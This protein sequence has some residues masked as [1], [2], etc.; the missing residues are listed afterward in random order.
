MLE[1]NF[2]SIYRAIDDLR[3]IAT[4]ESAQN[5]DT[6]RS[7]L[8]K[9]INKFFGN[10]FVCESIVYTENFDKPFFGVFVK[11]NV[12][13]NLVE[14][15]FRGYAPL[16]DDYEYYRHGTYIL[17]IDSKLLTN[18][19]L[20]AQEIWAVIMADLV[21][22]NGTD[23]TRAIRD[24]I[25][26]YVASKRISIDLEIINENK[27]LFNLAYILT[28]HNIS[29]TFAKPTID[30]YDCPDMISDYGITHDYCTAFDK[31]IRF[32]ARENPVD[33]S[34]IA[35]DW[36][37]SNYKDAA[38]NRYLEYMLK[39]SAKIEA[40]A[41]VRDLSLKALTFVC[42]TRS[43][44]NSYTKE[45]VT[46]SKRKG[47]IYQMKRNGIKS[48][49]EDLFEYNM[50]LRNVETQ[51]EAI[52]LMRQINSRMSILE[53][54]IKTEDIDNADR[55]RWEECYAKYLDLRNALSKKTVYNRKMYGLFVDYNALQNMSNSG[56]LMNTYY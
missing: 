10:D 9:E 24:M 12:S 17:E 40:S 55:A 22:A 48:I 54:Y 21:R 15:V 52:L 2:Y 46:E 20:T 11:P 25:D 13:N 43:Q 7:T 33:T 36:F 44:E 26:A 27:E 51:D 4:G 49:E 16:N 18:F 31:F 32:G 8:K 47:L 45:I 42:S 53:D 38:N 39:D 50:R 35:L 1:Y 41:C 29:S 34:T 19:D 30:Q 6:A 3:L 23:T 37:F 56:Q 28:F 14:D 5:I